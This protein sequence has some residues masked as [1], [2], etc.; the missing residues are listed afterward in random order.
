MGVILFSNLKLF[1]VN[2]VS[3]S[4][5]DQCISW[6]QTKDS[7]GHEKYRFN[8]KSQASGMMFSLVASNGLKISMNFMDKGIK[9]DSN[10]DLEILEMHM[11]PWTEDKVVFSQDRVPTHN[12]NRTQKWI[13]DN[14]QHYWPKDIQ[15]PS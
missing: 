4:H 15:P 13:S 8:T 7:P 3:N 9:S 6:Q 14:F 5:T 12:S 11:D 1:M 2:S 10:V